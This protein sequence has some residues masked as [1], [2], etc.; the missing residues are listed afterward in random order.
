MTNDAPASS[1]A[2]DPGLGE[3]VPY[4]LPIFVFLTLTSLEAYLPDLSWY[5]LA[6]TVKLVVVGVSLWYFRGVWREL[7]PAPGLYQLSL[8]VGLG[9]VVYLLWVGLDGWYPEFG[10]LGKR[11][12]LDPSTLPAGWKWPFVAVRFL[13]LVMLVPLMEEIFW[14][15]FLIRWLI[16]PNFQRVPLGTV[17]PTAAAI[18]SAVFAFSHPE[19][20]P[21]LCTGLIWA[22]LLWRTKSLS[23]CVVSHA[24]ANLALG[25]HVLAT[26]EW[27]YW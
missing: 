21:A 5:P 14:R 3:I 19:W 8:A 4:A 24:V 23:A 10:F 9:V 11:T 15:S 2:N 17:T 16:N 1:P 20:L 27:K 18:S 6:Y 7:R 22:W 12:G 25:L 26:G 13:G